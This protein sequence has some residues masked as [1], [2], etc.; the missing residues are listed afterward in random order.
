MI[1]RT[2]EASSL[3]A[4]FA[5]PADDLR[6]ALH[7]TLPRLLR[8][9]REH[10]DMDVAFLSE[11][12]DGCRMFRYVDAEGGKGVPR[13]GAGD[14][15]EQTYCQRI[16][17]GRLPELIN[18]ADAHPE[19]RRLAVTRALD[20]G[21]YIGVPLRL[22]DGTLYGTL[23]CYSFQPDDTLNRRDLGIMHL[24][25]DI[26]SDII[27]HEMESHREEHAIHAGVSGALAGT[28][29]STVYQPI[30][31]LGSMNAVGFE[32][33]TRFSD[34]SMDT[35][36]WFQSAARVGREIELELRAADMALRGF[37]R[38]PSACYLSLNVSAE[39][40][41]SGELDGLLTGVPMHRLVLEITE[42]APIPRYDLLLEAL[43][44]YRGRGARVAVDDA[45]AGY[46]SFRHILVLQPELIKLDKSLVQDVDSDASRRELA[47]ALIGFADRTGSRLVAEGVETERELST[48][49]GMGVGLGQGF[50]LGRPVPLAQLR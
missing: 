23:C 31:D 46:A 7:K 3:A 44:R 43:D 30:L 8:A 39:T 15:L 35:E 17:D 38:L 19:A 25:A 22:S 36:H 6:G 13:P 45:G 41:G 24:V 47:S 26:A 16:V 9:L 40:L 48:L 37:D 42:R 49:K 27:D 21:A 33:L 50:H 18:D 10:L 14:P 34:R 20:I 12:T 5:T 32:A 11:F 29:M 28:G 1:P 4:I 2:S